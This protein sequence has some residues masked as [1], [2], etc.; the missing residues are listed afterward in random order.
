MAHKH[1]KSLPFPHCT[2]EG[3]GGKVRTCVSAL[4]ARKAKSPMMRRRGRRTVA[5][6]VHPL[7][8]C[9]STVVKRPASMDRREEQPL[10]APS[11]TNMVWCGTVIVSSLAQ[12]RNVKALMLRSGA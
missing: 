8:A 9:F 12:S 10:K 6:D 2:T 11:R 5:R 4:Q 3:L 7:K 1:T